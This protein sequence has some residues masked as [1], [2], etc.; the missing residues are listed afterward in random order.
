MRAVLTTVTLLLVGVASAASDRDRDS[1]D[2]V[3]LGEE[4]PLPLSVQT[5]DDLMD[6]ASAS[7]S[8]VVFD[9]DHY[10]MGGVLAEQLSRGGLA[11]TLVTPEGK[12]PITSL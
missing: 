1:R 7:G 11:V 6:G 10:Y 2:P 12:E 3:W 9:D 8:V 5:P 4:L